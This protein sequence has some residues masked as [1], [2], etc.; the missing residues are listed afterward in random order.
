MTPRVSILMRA[1]NVSRF[2]PS[3]LASVCA[4]TINDWETLILDDASEDGIAA[5][6]APYIRTDKRFRYIRNPRRLGRPGNLNRGLALAR[7]EV[8]AVLDGDDEWRDPSTLCK[9]TET[10]AR[11]PQA[12]LIAASAVEIDAQGKFLRYFPNGHHTDRDV[13][14][15]IL[16]E[17]II[18]H[19]S[20]CYRKKDV[21]AIGRY[22]E[23]LLYTEDYELWLRL[24]LHGQFLKIPD[25]V[26]SYRI[27]HDSIGIRRRHQQILEEIKVII[28]Y[29]QA[30]PHL[31]I[32]LI[33]R[34]LSLAASCI[35]KKI[36]RVVAHRFHYHSLRMRLVDRFASFY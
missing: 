25:Y 9:L 20:V 23:R 3:A 13:R 4:Q 22:N 10:L 31:V 28:R 27:H 32:A 2:L 15:C 16:I 30:Y 34:M 35:P 7:G 19:N 17:N 6:V 14:E 36:R 29:R 18:A 12:S 24:G 1:C 5:A 11:N 21:R 8:I 33:N 26:A